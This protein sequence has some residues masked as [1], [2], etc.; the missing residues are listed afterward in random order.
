MKYFLSSILLISAVG[1]EARWWLG[2]EHTTGALAI[3]DPS[4]NELFITTEIWGQQNT[5]TTEP[6]G[7]R[8]V[9]Q[10]LALFNALGFLTG[11]TDQLALRGFAKAYGYRSQAAE[12]EQRI[13]TRSGH[14]AEARAG[15][16]MVASSFSGLAIS[17]GVVQSWLIV[18]YL[19]DQSDG[20]ITR[21]QDSSRLSFTLPRVA[22]VQK[23]TQGSGGMYFLLGDEGG[24]TYQISAPSRGDQDVANKQQVPT[25][26]GV[27]GEMQHGPWL[28]GIDLAYIA[29][30][31][32][33]PLSAIGTPID[34][35]F[36]RIFLRVDNEMSSELT[37]QNTL[38]LAT[39]AYA[40]NAYA[41]PDTILQG[42]LH[43]R[44]RWGNISGGVHLLYGTDRVSL[45][46]YHS[47]YDVLG[48]GLSG[49]VY[50]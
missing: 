26:F 43:S 14:L 1:A 45:P 25:E 49:G 4:V 40:H 16:D 15:L 46:E 39:P 28:F 37:W 11:V 33:G 41:T 12:V 30:A 13:L 34:E 10:R 20:V 29:A 22:I 21:T 36:F 17:A 27:V 31:G 48:L 6:P 8:Y 38:H 23:L 19:K 18:D 5:T 7:T 44:M 9:E 3:R 24:V 35:D 32:K 2:D 47:D 50:F 42:G